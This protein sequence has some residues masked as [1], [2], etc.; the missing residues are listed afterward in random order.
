MLITL[1]HYNIFKMLFSNFAKNLARKPKLALFLIVIFGIFL[2]LVF[3]SG[4]G[5]S[6]SLT[7][8]KTA[9]NIDKGI[10]ANSVLTLSTRLG[11]IYPT[12]ISY[13]IFGINDFSSV[14]FVLLTS[15]ASIILIFYFGKLL[16]NTKI[17][18]I[19]AF[20]LSFFP[21]DVVYS[22][23]LSSDLPSAFF[24]ALGI[25][26]FL[27][28]ELKSKLKY[29]SIYLLS[30]IF[31][32]IGYLIRES[33]LLIALFFIAYILYK[34]KV[35]KE[36]FLVPAGVL[37]VFIFEAL[38]FFNLTQDFLFR[39]HASQDYLAKASLIRNYFGRLD[40]PTGL[41]HYPWL[42]LTNSLL[43]F[44]YIFILSAVIYYIVFRKKET[45]TLL[46][47]FIPLLLYLSFG[48]SSLSQYIP[49]SAVDRYTSIIAMPGI[50]LLSFFL[51]GKKWNMK[52]APFLIVAFLFITS[53]T[54]VYI[55]EDRNQL[56]ELRLAYDHIKNLDK[57]TV[58]IDDRSAEVLSY[59]AKY[60][61]KFEVVAYP[62]DLSK[63][64]DSYIMINKKM[65]KGLKDA[66]KNRIFP[67]EIEN[68]PKKWELTDEI[69]SND[70]DKIIIYYAP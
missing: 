61:D 22:T 36:Y 13:K 6:D 65:I 45:Y 25:Y 23:K 49:L 70:E 64:E 62:T 58:Y 67:D 21:L 39:V 11:L 34:R 68:P 66:N 69:G 1:K 57:K 10:D 59:I 14:L 24:M 29:G 53:I 35:K 47:W 50:L 17:G 19:A 55:R 26:I 12:A 15:I 4:M 63:I 37:M 31:I 27:Y 44:F 46:F 40:F 28:A 18:M 8:S 54:S 32:G 30:G 33:A 16:F 51:A 42:F 5:V 2:R 9:Y 60:E 7:Y 52:S 38:I 48:S 20:L 56:K 41:F 3:F 43:V